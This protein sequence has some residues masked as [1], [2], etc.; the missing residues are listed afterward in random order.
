MVDNQYNY[1]K[2]APDKGEQNGPVRLESGSFE[3]YIS[4]FNTPDANSKNPTGGSSNITTTA[5]SYWL[6]KLAPLGKQ[7][8]AGK[9]YELYRDVVEYG[10][11]NTGKEDATEAINAAI[12]DGNRCGLECGNTFAQGAIIYFPPGTYKIC[13]PVIQLYYTQFI[14]DAL[15]PP[16][17][18]GCD[19]FQGIALFDTDPY[20]PNGNGQ[21][22]YINQNQFF[23]QIRNFI[24]DLTEM[25]LTT[26]DHD[27]PLVPTG[28][29]WQVSQACSLQ[30]LVFNMPEATD[31]N[32]VTH[33]GIFMENG[34]GGF[35]SDLVFNGGNIGWRA[36]SQQYTAM[37]LKFNGC[38]T[39]VQM[40]WDWGFN[41]QRIEVDGGAI[42]FNISG[43]GGS[44]GQGIGSVSI[45]DSKISNC[46]IAILTNSRED[47]IN[48]PPN[49]V[50]DNLEMINVE[51]TVKSENGDVILDGTDHVGL[52]A[53]GRRYKGYKGTYV[54]GDVEAPSKGKRLL[55][56]DGK[57]FYRPRP[58][59]EDLG[60]DQ[61]LIATENGCKN[62][63]TGDN[64][65]DINAFLE[66]A[67][68]ERKIA[69]FP[70]GIYRVGG[71]VLI[72]TGSRVQGS[73][74]SQIQGA[75]FYFNDIHNP[76]VVV[77]VGKKGDVGDME[78][79]DM[80]FT[81]QGATAGAIV[82]E[83]N[84]HEDSQGSA[85]MWDSHVR[86][87]GALGTDLDI[88]TCPKFEFSDAC[89]CASLLFHVTPQ[90]SGY[91]E[92][93]WIWLA[94]HDNDMSVYDSPDKIANQI[95][96]YAAR[97]TLIE[98][99][100]PSWFY[101]TGSEHTVLYQY[102]VYGA[103]DIYLGHIQTETP[104]YQP[105]PIAPLP[106]YSAKKF[107]GDP[108]FEECRTTGCSTAWGLR[109]INSEGVTLHS[110]GLYSFFQ[111]YYQDCVPTH[112]CQERVLE[113]RGSKD[114]ALFNIFTVGI[115][116]IGTGINNGAVF[117]N[118]SNQS[119]FTTE[120]SVWLP[121]PGD[122]EY[123][124]VYVG[125]DVYDN[126]SVTCPADC[127]LV[128]PTSSLAS[129]T[130]IDPGDYTT[131]LEYGH[132]GTTTIGGREVPTFYTTVTTITLDIDPITTDGMPYSNI[133]I[134]EG[135]PS[136][137][138]T[139]LPSV[140]IP[141][142]PVPM[143][144]GE[145]KTT[146]RNV[147]VP[148]WPAI[149][150]GPPESWSNPNTSPTDGTKEGV[151]HTPFV[152]TVVATH[153]T[154][155]TL[156]FPST[157]S[158]IVVKC[159]PNS[160]V[161]FNTPKTT[162]TIYCRV[163]TTVSVAFTCP[164]TK[165]VTFIGSSTG[166]F[167]V[168]CTVSTTFTKPEETITP[169]PTNE[170]T[171]TLPLP[172]WTTWP[173]GA[174]TPVE[175]EIEEPEPG[176]TTCDL[177]FFSICLNRDNSIFGGLRWIL[178]PGIYPPGPPPARAINLPPSWT[179][180]PPLPPWPPITVGRDNIIT[181]PKEEPTKCEKTSASIC[182]TS[183]FKTTTTKGPITSTITSTSSTCNTIYGCSA[184][185]WDTTT[186]QTQTG[187]CQLP[188]ALSAQA[189]AAPPIP[190]PGC[191]A[192]AIVYPS[193]MKDVGQIPQLLEKY[194]GKYVEIKS[195]VLRLTTFFWVPFLDQETMNALLQSPDVSEAY[196]YERWNAQ[197]HPPD[198][199]SSSKGRSHL[200]VASTLHG[201]KNG[202]HFTNGNKTVL[203]AGNATQFNKRA[204]KTREHGL[205]WDLSQIS[206]PRGSIW[207]SPTSHTVGDDEEFLFH[208]D[209]I[210]GDDQYIYIFDEDGVW[211]DHPEMAYHDD[212]EILEPYIPYGYVGPI[213]P[214]LKHG[215]RVASKI[216]GAN[217]GICQRCTLIVVNL[218]GSSQAP[219]SDL[220]QERY[221]E[222]LLHVLED[223]TQKRRNGKA[224][225]N[226]SF[227]FA[228][229]LLR[230]PF[231]NRLYELFTLLDDQNVALL[232]ASSNDG[233]QYRPI[234]TYPSL[235]GDPTSPLYLKNLIVVG[236]TNEDG[237]LADFSHYSN[238]MTTF[239][240][241]EDVYAPTL[242]EGGYET[243]DGTSL[244]VALVSGLV[245]YYRSL[246][247]P[248][249][250]QLQSPANVKKMIKIFHRRFAVQGE[251]VNF[252]MMK[253]TIWNAQV[254]ARSC[255]SDYHEIPQWDVNRVCPQIELDLEND[256]N[257]GETVEPCGPVISNSLQK[258][259]GSYCPNIPGA[260]SGGHT[261]SFT[262]NGGAKPSPTCAS[263]TGCGGHLCTGFFCSP[264]P[265]G[266]PPDRHDPKDPNA[267]NPVPTTTRPSDPDPTCDDKCKLDRGN[268]CAC[269]ENGC[270]DQSPGCCA[271]ASCP[272][273]ECNEN[274]CSPGSPWCCANDT[275]EW[276]R[277]GGGGGY[278]PR[279]KP[280]TG[281]VLI[282]VSSVE[283]PAPPYI[284]HYW[285][286]WSKLHPNKVDL[287]GDEPLVK[288][289]TDDVKGA[290]PPSLGPFTAN[291]VTC[292]YIG[293]KKQA[294][295]LECDTNVAKT[296]CRALDP[297]ETYECTLENPIKH[298]TV[299][300]EWE[301]VD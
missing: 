283:N 162:P 160:K 40:I 262:S 232:A 110:S 127:I 252:A 26:D 117:Q 201:Q 244:S 112:N 158:P 147:T 84:V 134:T 216:L 176:K 293:D 5:S 227:Q 243:D 177:W 43:R 301:A 13:R 102:Q 204:V 9:D 180:K 152:T 97:G 63:G 271:N 120:V 82:L 259:A 132:H 219:L 103:K 12:K 128:F 280:R 225:I 202:N 119:G 212:I 30:N 25:P 15:D 71:T 185:D 178:P 206:M 47:R 50:I 64:A 38:L 288:E 157:V 258:L 107:P 209:D 19:T 22:W 36:G 245:G 67:T 276:S 194:E 130:T 270:D 171:T 274:S 88:E 51:T 58:Q 1:F 79:V 249:E 165:V 53:I 106:F 28:I 264:M 6:P 80:M 154:V 149:T 184:S 203:D 167:T 286:V 27:Q 161:P 242:D 182:A 111:E 68:K 144:D 57:L 236:A 49:I 214:D 87:G 188:T 284:H 118:D 24:F 92:N 143:P 96:I 29:H 89:I 155:S 300:C 125:P 246:P 174:I 100:G 175:E 74:W 86:V 190:P 123:D 21:N 122:D 172:A 263:G 62:D 247:S 224:V 41:W 45:I 72:P 133:N 121:L 255:L 99:E 73:S 260:G 3:S 76:R 266:V 156:S 285:E 299:Q 17:I 34:S 287:C 131:S 222:Q 77:Q 14:G 4:M 296:S 205:I 230:V 207:R 281:F 181:Y 115:V 265:T 208:Y 95:S 213:Q 98:S 275:C 273:C 220:I 33:V 60:V 136:A 278:N 46:P 129:P 93:V 54:S 186:T 166:V 164:A 187:N 193:D 198:P 142:I 272:Y 218:Y 59:Y 39:A 279:P 290:F 234:N 254:G 151:Y 52:W 81:V 261:V 294:G 233:N 295:K 66:K 42:A 159:P 231:L 189:A 169:G 108:S 256:F 61:F 196:Y 268:R 197:V 138:L 200:A 10:A 251:P 183:V 150:R 145:G 153:P 292:E 56:K 235:F 113:V 248:W 241:G 65:G 101:G 170:P 267:G 69:Y 8:I 85:A 20:I 291:G 217:L 211:N 199:R 146:T 75:G 18:K 148:P 35:V 179:I 289:K 31:S 109:I 32:K 16:T 126:P 7:P 140:D 297:I 240:P 238:W 298:L 141:P 37:N 90:A 221:V 135:Q 237:H 192:N 269:N 70:A 91:F 250:A 215:T 83:W 191:P 114:V 163:P 137:T 228:E 239:A 124:I 105:V 23:R 78:I 48:G 94:D 210:S 282:S 168:D 277:T 173:P 11:D 104:Y 2:V 116:E 226:M 44:T 195:E 253:P 257:E 223:V 229:H 55:D 139:V